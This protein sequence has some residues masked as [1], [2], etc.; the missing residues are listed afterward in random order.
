MKALILPILSLA[1]L[2]TGAMAQ[3]KSKV[4]ASSGSNLYRT[5]PRAGS[6]SDGG[7]QQRFRVAAFKPTQHYYLR[8]TVISYRYNAEMSFSGAVEAG[9]Y[10]GPQGAIFTPESDNIPAA[11]SIRNFAAV[12]RRSQPGVGMAAQTGKKTASRASTPASRFAAK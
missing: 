8:D 5:I 3:S 4:S 11:A 6:D 7:K 2:T 1:I 12:H 10:L 9:S